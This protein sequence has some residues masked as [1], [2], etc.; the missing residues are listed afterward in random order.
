M[1]GSPCNHLPNSEDNETTSI[2]S[3]SSAPLSS[4]ALSRELAYNVRKQFCA[5]EAKYCRII[6]EKPEFSITLYKPAALVGEKV[7]LQQ[8][9]IQLDKLM[10]D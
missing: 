10:E 6:K 7:S 8:L 4:Q 1:S 9:S 2:S 5:N 3:H